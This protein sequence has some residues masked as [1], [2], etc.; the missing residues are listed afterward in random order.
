M[1]VYHVG[2]APTN[3]GVDCARQL[4]NI[5]A[6]PRCSVT[7]AVESSRSKQQGLSP[8]LARNLLALDQ[9]DVVAFSAKSIGQKLHVRTQASGVGHFEAGDKEYVQLFFRPRRDRVEDPVA[10]MAITIRI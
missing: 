3:L 5:V 7:I 6:Q 1:A 4:P 2:K 8:R 9:A 10:C